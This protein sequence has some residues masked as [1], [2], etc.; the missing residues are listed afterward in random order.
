MTGNAPTAGSRIRLVIKA[1]NSI[2]WE[3]NYNSGG[4]VA[5]ET[6]KD[7]RTAT[8]RIYHDPAHPSMLDLPVVR[9]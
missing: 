4:D 2:A 9:W 6:A 8:V 5:R 7:A 3:K 1:L